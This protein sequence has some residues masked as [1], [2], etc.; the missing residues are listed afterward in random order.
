LERGGR[1]WA[2]SRMSPA[3]VVVRTGL[4]AAD[5]AA[6]AFSGARGGLDMSETSG[7]PESEMAGEVLSW[8]RGSSLVGSRVGGWFSRIGEGELAGKSHSPHSF[9]IRNQVLCTEHRGNP[10]CRDSVFC[11]L[12]TH[13]STPGLSLL[14]LL[15]P[16]CLSPGAW[17]LDWVP[18][19]VVFS[20]VVFVRLRL[21][22]CGRD[23]LC[24]PR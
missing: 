16:S 1:R 24:K 5:D 4:T 12:Y 23:V 8:W 20:R 6:A 7:G 19:G 18:E 2:V 3:S 14:S 21:S 15:C 22:G 9:V 11:I 10:R 17:M 13:S